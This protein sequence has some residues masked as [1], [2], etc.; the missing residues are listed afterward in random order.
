MIH[1]SKQLKDKV[2]NISKGDNN[3]AKTLIRNFMME[4]FL[5]RISV[6]DYRDRMILKGGM[7][8]AAIVG[9]DMRATMDIDTTVK[10]LPVNADNAHK[11]VSEIC[12]IPLE[13]GVRFHIT[14]ASNIMTDFKYPGI[15]MM[16]EATLERLRQTIRIDISTDD[17]ITPS[18][19]E[20]EY[21]LMFEDRTIYLCTYNVET[22]LAEKMQTVLVRGIANT[23]LRDFYDIYEVMSRCADRVDKDILRQAFRATCEKR[24]TIFLK[25]EMAET[26]AL[27]KNDV[28]MAG[29]WEQFR[30]KNYFVGD[31]EWKDVLNGVLDVVYVYI[32]DKF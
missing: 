32:A 11:I 20:Y 15:R 1:T 22:L 21:K 8:V 23:R 16:L 7:L 25:E 13:D 27:I 17:V 6:S 19:V 14:S 2:R 31:L 3:I 9:I 28:G 12:A 26:L 18:A 24:G 29:M 4:R 30:K 10:A 5:E